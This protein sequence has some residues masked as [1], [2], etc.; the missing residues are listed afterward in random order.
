MSGRPI[1]S[2]DLPRVDDLDDMNRRDLQA[3]AKQLGVKANQKSSDIISELVKVLPEEVPKKTSSKS[4]KGKRGLAARPVNKENVMARM[5]MTTKTCRPLAAAKS[6]NVVK[7]RGKVP[8]KSS[9]YEKLLQSSNNGNA[10]DDVETEKQQ[11]HEEKTDLSKGKSG[12]PSGSHVSEAAL[13]AAASFE[14]S[15]RRNLEA[16]EAKRIKQQKDREVE[17]G[18]AQQDRMKPSQQSEEGSSKSSVVSAKAEQACEVEEASSEDSDSEEDVDEIGERDD[19]KEEHLCSSVQAPRR[20]EDSTVCTD[21]NKSAVKEGVNSA[22]Q[23][24]KDAQ[25]HDTSP[26]MASELIDSS[27]IESSPIANA[28]PVVKNEGQDHVKRSS[29]DFEERMQ[30]HKK[31]ISQALEV[32]RE[33]Q[34][35]LEQQRLSAKRQREQLTKAAEDFDRDFANK[36]RK[37]LEAREKR[38]QALTLEALELGLNMEKENIPPRNKRRSSVC[39]SSA[40]TISPPSSPPSKF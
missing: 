4:S 24:K 35:K 22:T 21:A 37:S 15:K 17:L 1:V 32:Q 25:T 23:T 36:R 7:Q 33:L 16:L 8:Q 19:E 30:K 18:P 26:A 3:L 13:L 34:A 5:I 10:K 11:R 20:S 38:A 6:S 12:E 40:I 14:K 27:P 39:S 31:N 9:K 2:Q 28:A 29:E